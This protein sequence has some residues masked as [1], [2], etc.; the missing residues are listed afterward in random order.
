MDNNLKPGENLNFFIE[1]NLKISDKIVV[2]LTSKYKERAERRI[3]GVGYEYSIIN[4]YLVNNIASNSRVILILKEGNRATSVP[5]FVQQYLYLDFTT[6]EKYDLR[7]KELLKAVTL[8]HEI[9]A[10][11]RTEEAS[12]FPKAVDGVTKDE[13]KTYLANGNIERAIDELIKRVDTDESLNRDL[14]VLKGRLKRANLDKRNGVLTSED[15]SVIIN[16]I[17]YSLIGILENASI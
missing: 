14:I 11:T 17:N 12:T 4:N 10:P 15:F 2:I 16:R 6:E 8:P 13:I 3:G 1:N 7:F 5:D 9:P